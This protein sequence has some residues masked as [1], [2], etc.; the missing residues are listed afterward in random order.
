MVV[1]SF[2]CHFL[3]L[4]FVWSFLYHKNSVH[5]DVTQTTSVKVL[6]AVLED[7]ALKK[8][9]SFFNVQLKPQASTYEEKEDVQV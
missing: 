1:L 2:S 4:L 6:A 7:T 5:R 9:V 8:E 3:F